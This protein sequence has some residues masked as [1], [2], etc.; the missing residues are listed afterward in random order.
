MQELVTDLLPSPQRCLELIH[1]LLP[2]LA[3]EVYQAFIA[4]VHEATRKLTFVPTSPEEF[5]D[6]LGFL[7]KLE[8][9][10]HSMDEACDHVSI[11]QMV[12]QASHCVTRSISLSARHQ[13][14]RSNLPESQAC[15]NNAYV[16]QTWH[17]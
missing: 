4:E 13:N 16:C 9:S 1:Q 15:S 10:R 17:M 12:P 11:A 6:L 3:S 2:Q 14:L 5:A 8:H 7:D